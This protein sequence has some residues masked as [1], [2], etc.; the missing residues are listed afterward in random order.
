[1]E[2]AH[3]SIDV[4]WSSFVKVVLESVLTNRSPNDPTLLVNASV[5]IG[6]LE[7]AAI[8]LSTGMDT[9]TPLSMCF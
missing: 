4:Y 3:T 1:M 6:L 5:E 7:L 9:D 2:R 8:E